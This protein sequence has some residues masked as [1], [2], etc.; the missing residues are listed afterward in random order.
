MNELVQ[1]NNSQTIAINQTKF[2]RHKVDWSMTTEEQIKTYKQVYDKRV[3]LEDL[4]SL[5]YGFFN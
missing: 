5:P 2:K 1:K 3:L 4:S